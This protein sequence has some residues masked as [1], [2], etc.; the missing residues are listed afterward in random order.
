VDRTNSK[1]KHSVFESAQKRINQG[2]SICIFPEGKVPDDES[3]VLDEFKNG[4][5][6]L[7][8]D[9]QLTIVPIAFLDNKKC[10]SYTFFS[11]RPGLLR[12]KVLSFID[13]NNKTKAD[14]NEIRNQSWNVIH[15]E[16]VAFQ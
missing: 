16:L 2:L 9:H 1:S 5:F 11:G 7:A 13:T 3:I 15:K 8:I 14:L 10:F 6:R 4:A 12:V